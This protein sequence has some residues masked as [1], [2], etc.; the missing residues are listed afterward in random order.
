M[1]RTLLALVVLVPLAAAVAAFAPAT[2]VGAQVER[3]SGGRLGFAQIEGTVWR[4]RGVIAAG[5]DGRVALAWSID[6]WPLLRGELRVHLLPYDSRSPLPRGEIIADRSNFAVRDLDIA[7]PADMLRVA[8]AGHGI[9][10]AGELRVTSPS[11]DASSAGG[12]AE[13]VW[14][15][16]SIAGP[17]GA[18][19]ALGSV[20]A[21]VSATDA[22]FSGSVAN[23]GGDLDVRGTVA[24]QQDGSGEIS[25][26]LAPR[27]P[28]NSQ[29]AGLLDAIGTPEGA[30]RRVRWRTGSR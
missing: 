30:G 6:V 28:D 17:V 1:R 27:L 12:T 9:R 21:V 5:A 24:R 18:P 22:G 15:D 20:A 29:I 14:R 11:F 10:A 26:L 13:L 2:L 25:L 3:S 16:A 4:G 19:I 8:V 23:Q 7:M